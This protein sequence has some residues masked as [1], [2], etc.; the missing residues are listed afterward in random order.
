MSLQSR[1]AAVGRAVANRAVTPG[2]PA[3]CDRIEELTARYAADPPAVAPE[4]DAAIRAAVARETGPDG[5]G[6]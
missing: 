4:I 5:E 3:V 2:H 6:G 1:L